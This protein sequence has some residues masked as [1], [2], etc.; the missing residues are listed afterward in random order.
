MVTCTTF[1]KR[2]VCVADLLERIQAPTVALP[3]QTEDGSD[4]VR[5]H[6]GTEPRTINQ[7]RGLED[8]LILLRKLGTERGVVGRNGVWVCIRPAL[9]DLE[10]LLGDI[11]GRPLAN[12]FGA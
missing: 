8:V 10:Q 3:D 6:R 11:L 12:G 2:V 9:V 1:E 5:K 4:I 7:A